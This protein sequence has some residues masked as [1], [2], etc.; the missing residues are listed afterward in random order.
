MN[1]GPDL[2]LE[3]HASRA[4]AL[5]L[6]LVHGAGAACVLAV[7]PGIPG[8]AVAALLLALGVV[9]GRNLALLRGRGAV[10]ALELAG[11]G[12]AT[13]EL[14]DGQRLPGRVAGRRHVS[15][16]W[17]ML[18]LQGAARRNLLVAADML[19]PAAFRQ[20]RLWALWGRTGRGGGA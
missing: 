11:E 10:R 18:P 9:A 1:R 20:L 7:F 17:V 13:I 14:A 8:L 5:A 19:A 15:A 3:L 6:A 2:R 4:L 12:R 16:L